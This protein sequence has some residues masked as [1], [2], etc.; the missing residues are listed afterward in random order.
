MKKDNTVKHL[1]INLWKSICYHDIKM[2][3]DACSHFGAN[4]NTQ[5]NSKGYGVQIK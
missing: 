3:N 1:N 2:M 4:Q 5:V